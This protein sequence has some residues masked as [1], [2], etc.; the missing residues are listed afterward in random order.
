MN[1]PNGLKTDPKSAKSPKKEKS[2][3]DGKAK[4]RVKK[5]DTGK[6]SASKSRK[7]NTEQT[8][9]TWTKEELRHLATAELLT[10]ACPDMSDYVR[11]SCGKIFDADSNGRADPK[12]S[13]RV[14]ALEIILKETSFFGDDDAEG[15]SDS[16]VKVVY[17]YGALTD[18]ENDG[19][20]DD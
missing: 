14:K 18:C 19:G 17:D 1:S 5:S 9:K 8:F 12:V 4:K 13:D 11:K 15:K 10:I 16:G 6:V 20:A 3:A 7:K 2:S